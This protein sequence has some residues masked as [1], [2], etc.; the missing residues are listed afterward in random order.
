[1]IA[2]W[3]RS[4]SYSGN[5]KHPKSPWVRSVFSVLSSYNIF[6]AFLKFFF[7]IVALVDER[8]QPVGVTVQLVQTSS[9]PLGQQLV[10]PHSVT[11][12]SDPTDLVELARQ[13]Q[14][15]YIHH[16]LCMTCIGGYT[17]WDIYMY[18]FYVQWHR[19]TMDKSISANI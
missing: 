5:N 6:L 13:V 18:I 3:E 11:K 15:V 7:E 12:N 4:R 9:R 14:K 2:F 8:S 19:F 17:E 10:N 1:M 16:T